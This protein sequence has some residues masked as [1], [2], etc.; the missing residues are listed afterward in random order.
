MSMQILKPIWDAITP[1][2]SIHSQCNGFRTPKEYQLRVQPNA[3]YALLY[4]QVTPN[5][6]IPEMIPSI[7]HTQRYIESLLKTP[8]PTE[9]TIYECIGVQKQRIHILANTLS[10]YQNEPNT[11]W[12]T[13]YQEF[14][15][16]EIKHYDIEP[17]DG[18]GQ[19]TRRVHMTI[20]N[21]TQHIQEWVQQ[22][23]KH[24][25]VIN[26]VFQLNPKERLEK[27]LSELYRSQKELRAYFQ[28]QTDMHDTFMPAVKQAPDKLYAN[29]YHHPQLGAISDHNEH[30]V[31]DLMNCYEYYT[32]HPLG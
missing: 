23:Q 29:A 26:D 5:T 17:Q 11:D 9:H 27:A 30:I 6:Y 25:I 8:W 32:K 13:L 28:A 15:L 3:F 24:H 16:V 31:K 20:W 1:K 22:L 4:Q 10:V 21:A 14:Y 2:L 7:N 19:P 12:S 18:I